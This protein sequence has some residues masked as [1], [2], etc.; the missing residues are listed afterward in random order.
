MA[1]DGAGLAKERRN[2]SSL[3]PSWALPGV[4]EAGPGIWDAASSNAG[5]SLCLVLGKSPGEG[6]RASEPSSLHRTEAAC[7]SAPSWVGWAEPSK[8]ESVDRRVGTQG[9]SGLGTKIPGTG[10]ECPTQF[11]EPSPSHLTAATT[12]PS[13]GSHLEGDI[14]EEWHTEEL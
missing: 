1:K 13:L 3:A 4:P 14:Q 12:V 9:E 11:S 7:W 6:L 5:G 8:A 10:S 2:L